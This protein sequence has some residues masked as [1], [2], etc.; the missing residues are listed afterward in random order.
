MSSCQ[1]AAHGLRSWLN[2][3]GGAG[4]W[5]KSEGGRF[6]LSSQIFSFTLGSLWRNLLTDF[7][8][9]LIK[10]KIANCCRFCST[11][12]RLA[13]RQRSFFQSSGS[14]VAGRPSGRLCSGSGWWRFA[15]F[16]CV[17][18][19][20]QVAAVYRDPSV[21]NLINIMIVKLIVVHNEQ[22]SA[23]VATWVCLWWMSR[24]VFL[25][26]TFFSPCSLLEGQCQPCQFQP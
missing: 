20:L 24:Q 4:A 8:T 14:E 7:N 5:Q 3:T 19:L 11:L 16:V 23:G 15:F 22:V 26:W 18:F 12:W 6:W 21:G 1:E 2:M 25:A 10:K 9:A 17:L 13:R